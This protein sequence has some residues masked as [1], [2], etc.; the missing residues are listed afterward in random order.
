MLKKKYG[1]VLRF[2]FSFIILQFYVLFKVLFGIVV[3]IVF[4]NIFYLKIYQINIFNFL[5]NL[6][7]ILV[8]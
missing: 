2:S 8:H 4:Q 7:F 1:C 3:M 5:K 6:F